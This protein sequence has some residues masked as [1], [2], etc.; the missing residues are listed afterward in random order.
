MKSVIYT[1]NAETAFNKNVINA[2]ELGFI[3]DNAKRKEVYDSTGEMMSEKQIAC[4]DKIQRKMS[5]KSKS[6][7]IKSGIKCGLFTVS[8][9]S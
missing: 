5:G 1:Q 2:W 8:I 3:N 4:F 9:M 6:R 7:V